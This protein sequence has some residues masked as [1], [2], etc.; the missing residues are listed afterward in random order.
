[1]DYGM[2]NL[3]SVAK[4]V[5]R[6][7]ETTYVGDDLKKLAQVEKLILPGVGAFGDAVCELKKRNLFHLVR[8]AA[9]SGT[10]LL[11]IC[12][13]LQLFFERSQESPG[14]KGL[15]IWKG[16]VVKFPSPEQS[17]LKIPHMGWN[18]VS[19]KRQSTILAHVKEGS[20]FY[21]V[22]SYYAQPSERKLILGET[23]YGITF[24]SILGSATTF[25]V[26]FHPEK[27]QQVGLQVL[28]NFIG[29]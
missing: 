4:A 24:P 23:N 15:G 7:G 1:M 19:L 27:S 2:G 12:L 5:E 17:R 21:F 3:R 14:V 8:D 29:L 11:G 26:Q 10:P 9:K 25:A 22:H 16:S 13:G 18:D 6:F 20:Y 28:K